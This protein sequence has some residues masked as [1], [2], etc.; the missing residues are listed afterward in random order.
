MR[1]QAEYFQRE[2]NRLLKEAEA[3]DPGKTV[4]SSATE[5]VVDKPKRKYTKKK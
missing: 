1:S 2:A 3:L 4:N 5:A